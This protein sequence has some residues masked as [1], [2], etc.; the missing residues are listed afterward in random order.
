LSDGIFDI[1]FRLSYEI[2]PVY[3][4]Q[5]GGI[6]LVEIGFLGSFFAIA[7]MFT[8]IISGKF[9]D[10][11][12]ER[13]PIAMGFFLSFLAFAN[14]LFANSYIGFAITWIVF[15]LGVGV[16]SPAYQSLI[17]KIVPQKMLGTF[18]GLF[19]GSLGVVSLFAPWLGSQLWDMFSPRTPFIVTTIMI[20]F[21]VPIVW[22]KFILPENRK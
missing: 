3:L 19:R 11:F 16:L 13:V 15:G 9:S 18:T 22:L 20:A 1:S 10:R 21:T 2:M 7:M 8:P 6:S 12:G 14:F 4:E 5:F 17:S